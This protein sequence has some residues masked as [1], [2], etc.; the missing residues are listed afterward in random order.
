MGLTGKEERIIASYKFWD[1]DDI[2][3]ERL[4]ATVCDE[5]DCDVSDITD[6]LAKFEVYR[7]ELL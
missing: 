6:A 3:T 5:C 4:F 1:D 7:K 2:S